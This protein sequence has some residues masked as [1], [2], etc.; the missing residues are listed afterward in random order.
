MRQFVSQLTSIGRSSQLP[1]R[2]FVEL[3][4][5]G[6]RFGRQPEAIKASG[7]QPV[8]HRV[9]KLPAIAA[10]LVLGLDE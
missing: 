10:A 1:A 2:G 6:S 5:P 4:R 8:D 7:P 9:V 3:L